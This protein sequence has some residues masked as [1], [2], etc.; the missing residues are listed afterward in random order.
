ME[1]IAVCSFAQVYD[2]EA[3]WFL[4]QNRFLRHSKISMTKQ[5]CLKGITLVKKNNNKNGGVG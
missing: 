4:E 1:G 5:I 3:T 2:L